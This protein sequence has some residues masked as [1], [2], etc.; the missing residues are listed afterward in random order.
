MNREH[1]IENIAENQTQT[2][3]LYV[4]WN[5]KKLYQHVKNLKKIAQIT[6]FLLTCVHFHQGE[7]REHFLKLLE[8]TLPSF[9]N[10]LE[11]PGNQ[12]IILQ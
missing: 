10:L 12:K 9:Y 7:K 5:A 6:Y 2:L 8:T 4:R 3:K 1:G 11:Q